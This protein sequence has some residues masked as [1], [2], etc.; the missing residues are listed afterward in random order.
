MP[1]TPFS[2]K[3]RMQDWVGIVVFTAFCLCFCMAGSFG[4]TLYAW[5]SGSEIS[6]WVM[7]F[8][9]FVAFILVT[10]YH[11]LVAAELRLMPVGFMRTKDLIIIPLQGFLVAGSMMMSIYYTPLIFQFT[12]G[13]GP[14]MAGVRILPLICMIVFGCLFNGIAM[15]KLRYYMPWFV[16]GNALLVAGSALMSKKKQFN[17]PL[18]RGA[19]GNDADGAQ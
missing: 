7:T 10:I 12:K 3:M 15:P 13:D 5:K 9:L 19:D 11:P 4:G 17:N 2:K 1:D 18:K 8:L 6:L 16:V 14:L